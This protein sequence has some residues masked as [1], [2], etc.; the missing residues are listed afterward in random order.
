M[1]RSVCGLMTSE[2]FSDVPAWVQYVTYNPTT[3]WYEGWQNRPFYSQ[4]GH[5]QHWFATGLT[6]ALKRKRPEQADIIARSEQL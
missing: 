5:L 2:V 4:P 3:G 6:M 1:E